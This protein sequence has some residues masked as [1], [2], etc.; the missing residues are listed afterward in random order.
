MST[1]SGFGNY[2]FQ[3]ISNS[4]SGKSSMILF[5]CEQFYII[6]GSATPTSARDVQELQK[7]LTIVCFCAQTQLG[8]G[9][10]VV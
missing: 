7:A 3:Q 8:F 6:V 5:R 1:G 4:L 9:A 10:C 2:N